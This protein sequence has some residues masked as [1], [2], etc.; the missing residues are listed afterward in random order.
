MECSL[1]WGRL[2]LTGEPGVGKSTIFSKVVAEL[3]SLGC[4]VGGF[5][6]PEV[7]VG[8][9]RVGFRIV[10]LATGEEGWLARAGAP[11]RV[12][13]GRYAVVEEDAVRVGVRALERALRECQVVAVDE[14]GPM[15]LLVEELRRALEKAVESGRLYVAVVHRRLRETHPSIYEA[16]VARAPIIRVTLENRGTLASCAPAYA[17][18]IAS[19]ACY[20]SPL[21]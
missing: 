6:A 3:R 2:Y 16:L 15:E 21:T 11:G 1:P 20:Q 5:S 7:R 4:S 12:R 19:R 17:K 18:A 13:M 8:G 9:S 10:D 14:I